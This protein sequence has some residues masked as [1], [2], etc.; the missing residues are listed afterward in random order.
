VAALGL[1]TLEILWF[2]IE[3]LV[4]GN[5]TIESTVKYRG[6]ITAT[7]ILASMIYSIDWTIAAVALPHMQGTFSASQD[8]IS[9]VMTSYIVISAI[10]LPTTAWL[11]STFGRKRLFLIAIAG[12][13][14]FSLLCG[15]ANSLETEILFRAGQGC[16][17]AFLI[18][19]SQ[20][21]MLDSYPKE[22]HAK[23]TALWGLGVIL[24]P[25]IGPTIGGYLTEAY[26]WRWVFYVSVPIG[27]IAYI[28]GMLFLPRDEQTSGKIT[29]DWIGF[30]ALALCVGSLQMMLDR[31]ER[32]DWFGS[33][34]IQIEAGLCIL[35]L[36]VFIVHSLSSKQPIV[37]LRLMRD[38][39]YA[40]GLSF[41]FIYGML[42]LPPMILLPP[43]LS[44]LQGY[45]VSTVGLLLSPRGLGLMLAMFVLGRIG[46][47]IDPRL[48]LFFGFTTLGVPSLFMAGWTLDVDPFE[49]VWTGIIQ[50][51][52]AGA[53]VVPLGVV[54]F[55]TLDQKYRTEAASMWN[56][57][58]SAGSGIGISVA[59]FIVARMSN[60]TRAGLVEHI[61]PFN[62]A[63]HQPPLSGLRG[64][65][66]TK[67]L[68]IIDNE[69]TRQALLIGYIDVFQL[70]AWAAFMALP[71]I[72]LLRPQK[73]TN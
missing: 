32:Q 25:V 47:K 54:T 68:A 65:A 58:R 12:F 13:T 14:I 3:H 40:L 70:T 16:F 5:N 42:S 4:S 2:A 19:L 52:G 48:T 8:Q 15:A 53:I 61:S 26:S 39:N 10:M 44:S 31:G 51:M 34:E 29:F 21:L 17:G 20:A 63:L 33:L 72:L 49:V 9:W 24:G 56:L 45:P 50:G 41:V 6:L 55:A 18:P 22:Q 73:T 64:I 59:V 71:L 27:I 46:D 60:V 1:S 28:G 23:A 37:N 11:S 43:F 38:S 62:P 57:V 66:S 35:G 7:A 36:Y 30:A 69:V 67:N